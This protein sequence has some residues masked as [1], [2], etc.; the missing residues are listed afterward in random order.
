MARFRWRDDRGR[1][2]RRIEHLAHRHRR[3]PTRAG[4]G[5]ESRGQIDHFGVARRGEFRPDLGPVGGVEVGLD[6][7]QVLTGHEPCERRV[8]GEGEHREGDDQRGERVDVR[9]PVGVGPVDV[10]VVG[11][12]VLVR[13]AD[14]HVGHPD[15]VEVDEL[16]LVVVGEQHVAVLVVAV[17]ELLVLEGF[18]E[19]EPS[20]GE[21]REPSRIVE[22]VLDCDVQRIARHPG[23]DDDGPPLAVHAHALVE[24]GRRHD[25]RHAERVDVLLQRAVA[26]TAVVVRAQ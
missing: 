20:V 10:L 12:A 21:A 14:S 8:R 15:A 2:E 26:E 18:D 1:I 19:V 7:Q 22:T 13:R 9:A 25:R 11:M 4:E 23:H 5:V 3:V 17:R 16:E 24:P 6:E